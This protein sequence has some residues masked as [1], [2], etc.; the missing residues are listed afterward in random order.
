[1]KKVFKAFA[2]IAASVAVTVLC[3]SVAFAAC[4]EHRMDSG[5]ITDQPTCE[6]IGI[7]TYTCQNEGCDYSY[8]EKMG[9]LG[10]SYDHGVCLTCGEVDEYYV[11]ED[12]AQEETIPAAPS[13]I[14]EEPEAEV[15]A[16]SGVQHDWEPPFINPTVSAPDAITLAAPTAPL[17]S[18]V[19][20]SQTDSSLW[21]LCG[22]MVLILASAT[23]VFTLI[24]KP[25][26]LHPAR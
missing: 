14:P 22:G 2:A 9:N 21:F 7:V 6:L 20:E 19:P 12:D 16:S 3:S 15:S 8:V 17:T 26:L 13:Q 25:E 18:V 24:R 1:M 10:H 5:V 11:P 23:A 4:D